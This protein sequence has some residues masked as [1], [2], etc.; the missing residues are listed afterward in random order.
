MDTTEGK[1]TPRLI[2][3][4][5]SLVGDTRKVCEQIGCSEGELLAYCAGKKEPSWPELDRLLSLI[6]HEQGIIIAKN[7]ESL[8]QARA[9]H[10]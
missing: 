6:I 10:Q 2:A 9:K 4:A 3:M 8:A 1:T 5:V 7:R